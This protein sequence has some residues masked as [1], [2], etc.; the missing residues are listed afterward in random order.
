MNGAGDCPHTVNIKESPFTVGGQPSI[1]N[2]LHVRTRK[3]GPASP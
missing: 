2:V 3:E 1:S